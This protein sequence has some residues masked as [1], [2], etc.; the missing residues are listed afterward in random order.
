MVMT[1][2]VFIFG[3]IEKGIV[4]ASAFIGI[5][6]FASVLQLSDDILKFADLLIFVLNYLFLMG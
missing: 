6:L 1:V 4:S 3:H 2:R 5:V